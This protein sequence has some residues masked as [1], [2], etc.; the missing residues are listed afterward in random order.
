MLTKGNSQL[1]TFCDGQLTHDQFF[2]G[3]SIVRKATIKSLGQLSVISLRLNV[4]YFKTNASIW[5]PNS[6][7]PTLPALSVGSHHHQLSL[8]AIANRQTYIQKIMAVGSERK[9]LSGPCHGH[10]FRP[11]FSK[12]LS[13]ATTDTQG[14]QYGWFTVHELMGLW[15]CLTHIK[16][17]FQLYFTYIYLVR[18]SMLFWCSLGWHYVGTDMWRRRSPVEVSYNQ[19][20]FHS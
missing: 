10:I 7:P 15:K 19:R 3:L 18:V 5:V 11:G 6:Q 9:I 13:D 16:Y 4:C 14:S 17:C 1:G 2:L 20:M 8:F 12:E